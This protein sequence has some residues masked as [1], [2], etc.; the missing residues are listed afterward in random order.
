VIGEKEAKRSCNDGV[1]ADGNGI[2][3][4]DWRPVDVGDG[5]A[6]GGRAGVGHAVVDLVSK[7]VRAEVIAGG[8]VSKATISAEIEC[9]MSRATDQHGGH[10]IAVEVAVISQHAGSSNC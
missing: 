8:R 1:F 4:G 3:A 7:A 6:H 9:A 10:G 5:K 2:V